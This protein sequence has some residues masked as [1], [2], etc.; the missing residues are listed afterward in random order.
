MVRRQELAQSMPTD[1]IPTGSMSAD[2]ILTDSIATD[3]MTRLCTSRT[4]SSVSYL[5]EYTIS[6]G[7]VVRRQQTLSVQ[8]STTVRHF[9]M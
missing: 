3:S 8:M 9:S 2:I 4:A 5:A 6:L 1:G 7:Y